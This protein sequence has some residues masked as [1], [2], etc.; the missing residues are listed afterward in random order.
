M[1]ARRGWL[2][3]PLLLSL[4]A[5]CAAEEQGCGTS[6][7]SLQATLDGIV[8]GGASDRIAL[9]EAVPGDWDRVYVFPEKTD[10]AGVQRLTGL[11]YAG[12]AEGDGPSRVPEGSQLLVFVREGEALCHEPVSLPGAGGGVGWAFSGPIFQLHGI[13]RSDAAFR[14]VRGDGVAELALIEGE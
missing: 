14:I 5:G 4:L 6:A 1:G 9:T 7:G 13:A 8:G 12:S 10:A 2:W 3:A 11:E